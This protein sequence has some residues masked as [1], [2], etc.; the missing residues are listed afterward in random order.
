MLVAKAGSH[1]I[2]SVGQFAFALQSLKALLLAFELRLSFVHVVK[3][4]L[5]FWNHSIVSLRV[6]LHVKITVRL[7]AVLQ[8]QDQSLLQQVLRPGNLRLVRQIQL[9]VDIYLK[10]LGHDLLLLLFLLLCHHLKVVGLLYL[11]QE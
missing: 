2:Q 9:S 6:L 7:L 8:I 10:V 1:P 3:Y 11:L 5:V 4:S